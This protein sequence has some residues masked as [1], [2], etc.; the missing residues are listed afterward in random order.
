L[1][2]GPLQFALPSGNG[3]GV[4]A[5]DL[6]EVGNASVALLLGEEADKEPS[7]AFVG[8]SDEAVNPAMLSGSRAV[9]MLLA[10]GAGAHMDDTL[11]LWLG[12]GG[13]P[14]GT[15][16]ERAIVILPGKH[17]SNFWTAA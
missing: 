9:G 4:Q 11:G 15:V 13:V 7:G 8:C 3:I 1:G 12:H 17:R 6:C 5:G 2:W 10:G 16:C 14:L